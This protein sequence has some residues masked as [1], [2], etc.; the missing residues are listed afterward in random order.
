MGEFKPGK[1]FARP[2]L[3][4]FGVVQVTSVPGEGLVLV[5]ILVPVTVAGMETSRVSCVVLL[6]SLR[7]SQSSNSS[8]SLINLVI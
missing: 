8:F 3:R 2:V 1:V 4:R 7:F 6:Y 5:T